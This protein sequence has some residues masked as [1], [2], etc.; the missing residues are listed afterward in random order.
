[1]KAMILAAGLG[2]RLRPLTLERPKPA[3]PLLGKP[4][5]ARLVEGLMQLGVTEFRINLH[6]LPD[7]VRGIFRADPWDKL[8]VSFSYEEQI[9]GTAGGL[10]ANEAFFDEGT[11]LM[12]NGKIV[13]AFPLKE[14]IRFHQQRRALA[15]LVL[16]R[17][18]PPYR[19]FPVRIDE[20]GRLQ[21]FKGARPVA[22]PRP[23]A[24]VFTGIHI[25]EPEI[26]RFIPPGIFYEINDQVYPAAM[27]QGLPVYG[28][29]VEGYWGEPSNPWR[30]LEVQRDLFEASQSHAAVYVSPDARISPAA[31]LG[32]FV[33][34]GAGSVVED[35]ATIENAILWENVHVRGGATL[36]TC[37]IGSDV[38]VAGA[39]ID[40][41]IT[42]NGEADLAHD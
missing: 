41:V 17:Q 3:M 23:E 12:V 25:I 2:T 13:M 34:I 26:F 31:R 6:H 37:V 21:N 19:W 35:N 24:Y 14:A 27:E 36:K 5:V 42:R 15:T 32:P 29:P 20:E 33:S 38:I 18:Q 4:I 30:Y 8:P 16:V 40:K 11:F 9:L 39:C 22:E 28:F 10:K 1:M 7:T